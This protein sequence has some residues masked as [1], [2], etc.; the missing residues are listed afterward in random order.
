M[1]LGV[2]RSG[3]FS[4]RVWTLLE[5][6]QQ[7][8][9]SGTTSTYRI[10]SQNRHVST[11]FSSLFNANVNPTTIN[12]IDV[13]TTME[14]QD[15]MGLTSTNSTKLKRYNSMFDCAIVSKAIAN[16]NPDFVQAV[17]SLEQFYRSTQGCPEVKLL[18]INLDGLLNRAFLS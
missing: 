1:N 2:A 9:S 5:L 12:I 13:S 11:L 6:F 17:T 14:T 18:G 16:D 7:G 15:A 4:G 8:V 3:Y 10:S